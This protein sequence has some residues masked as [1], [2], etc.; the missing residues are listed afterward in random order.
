MK[1]TDL[2]AGTINAAT[3]RFWVALGDEADLVA[4][5]MK[6]KEDFASKVALFAINTAKG[7]ISQKRAREIMGRNFFGIEEAIKYYGITL[8]DV[9]KAVYSEVPFT[10]EMLLTC[11]DAYT[12]AYV[13]PLSI[14]EIRD[15]SKKLFEPGTGWRDPSRGVSGKGSWYDNESFARK[16]SE[17][18]YLI[19]NKDFP[20]DNRSRKEERRP[21]EVVVYAAIGHYQI[22]GEWWQWLESNDIYTSS[23]DS[24][25]HPVVVE[26][27]KNGLGFRYWPQAGVMG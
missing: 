24:D 14:L 2:P 6:N 25:G 18:W 13:F 1:W 26:T 21:A 22:T 16:R 19:R 3:Q 7:S 27:N 8:S 10:E 15:I 12:L 23:E 5:L 11:K 4:D 17:G 20:K 9:K